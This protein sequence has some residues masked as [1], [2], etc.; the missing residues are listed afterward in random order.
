[1]PLFS[2]SASPATSQKAGHV[3]L[4]VISLACV[5]GLLHFGRLLI[6]TLLTATIL[7]F[8]LEPFVGFFVRFHFPRA[9]ASFLVCSIAL[10]VLY[11]CGLGL[12]TQVSGLIEELPRY[13]QRFSNLI[14]GVSQSFE[15]AENTVY[16]SLVPKR[17]R[18]RE[19]A[20]QAAAQAQAEQQKKTARRRAAEPLP[21]QP[22]PVQE[23]RIQ[24]Q[25]GEMLQFLYSYVSSFYNVLL[26]ASFVPFLVYFMLSWRDHIR[27][28]YLQFFEGE[29][30][31]VAGKSWHGIAGMVRAYVVGNFLLGFL[32]SFVSWLFFVTINL[33]YPL[34]LAPLSGFLSL[35]PYVGLPMSLLPPFFGALMV[36]D[37]VAP[38]L[39]IGTVV[40]F[41]HLLA[42]N[43]LY[44]KLVG[45]RVHLNP[46]VV[47]VALM[48]WGAIWG[49]VGLVLAIPITAG[50]KAVCDN[51]EALQPHG[52]FLGD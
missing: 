11:L 27:L 52:R 51:V 7:A 2:S 28:S 24:R 39:I 34:L 22:P 46:L 23:V 13:S 10:L 4:T 26:M 47:T 50:V 31:L 29:E 17:I 43:L 5:V 48:F 6:V 36:Y 49:G 42:L 30:R 25:P 16:E 35:F 33:P 45:S 21:A 14:D 38:F 8:L 32:L 19:R 40:A 37:R 12:Y 1:M 18:D 20:T 3:A 44:P 41:L 9:L 15:K